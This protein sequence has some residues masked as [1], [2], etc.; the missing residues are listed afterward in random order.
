MALEYYDA[1]F[2]QY[3]AQ[4]AEETA[5]CIES[6]RAAFALAAAQEAA[7]AQH[8]LSEKV[9]QTS[10]EMARK[11]AERPVRVDRVTTALAS[12]VAFGA[13]CVSSG[14]HLAST[15]MPFWVNKDANSPSTGRSVFAAVLAVPAGSVDLRAPRPCGWGRRE[16]GLGRG[17]R[18]ARRPARTHPRRMPRPCL[19]GG[20]RGERR[21]AREGHVI[22][23]TG[24]PPVR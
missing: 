21:G 10:V 9:A 18:C 1:F 17:H 24:N 11:L 5:R 3:P 13:L 4:L 16:G 7:R 15:P 20:V 12:V 19:R 6:A 23:D 22:G 8:L 2:R 14:Y